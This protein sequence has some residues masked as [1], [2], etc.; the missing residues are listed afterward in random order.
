MD[1]ASVRA[2]EVVQATPMDDA[3]NDMEE[4]LAAGQLEICAPFRPH[5][6][7]SD[8]WVEVHRWYV[9]TRDRCS[10]PGVGDELAYAAAYVWTDGTARVEI[11][12]TSTAGS[13]NDVS[14]SDGL[15]TTGSWIALASDFRVC[16]ADTEDTITLYFRIK[17]GVA[18]TVWIAGAVVKT[19]P[20]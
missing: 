12:F 17:S 20:V 18:G 11:R 1:G 13:D 8:A 5:K 3:H 16:G 14:K 19:L 2:G 9:K 10:V 6:T 4:V 7:T 15:S